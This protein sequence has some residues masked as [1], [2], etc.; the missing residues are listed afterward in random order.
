MKKLV[1]IIYQTY[2]YEVKT[3][4]G[5]NKSIE[6]LIRLSK[7]FYPAMDLLC[8]ALFK[9]HGFN[10]GNISKELLEKA[11]PSSDLPRIIHGKIKSLDKMNLKILNVCTKKLILYTILSM[12]FII[13]NILIS[14]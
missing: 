3:E 9:K 11:G 5:I 14:K 4:E 1:C 6:L 8:I 13:Q 2:I 12:N 10:I 7:L